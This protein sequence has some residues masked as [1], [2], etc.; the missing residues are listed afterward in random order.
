[1]NSKNRVL[2]VAQVARLILGILMTSPLLLAAGRNKPIGFDGAQWIWHGSP[3]AKPAVTAPAQTVYLHKGFEFPAGA[4]PVSGEVL[5]TCDNQ[6]T[7]FINGKQVG[8]SEAGRDAWMR[9]KKIDISNSLIIEQNAIAVKA[10]NTVGGP[11][12]LISRWI[13]RPRRPSVASSSV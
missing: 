12:G 5:I 10:V 1:M 3:G 2:S 11:A 6:W 4:K 9:P 13:R 7:L 8:Q